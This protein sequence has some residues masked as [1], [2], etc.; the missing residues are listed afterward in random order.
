M[1]FRGGSREWD[2]CGREVE[3]F[4]FWALGFWERGLD[5]EPDLGSRFAAADFF[6]IDQ[7]DFAFAAQTTRR[8]LRE[9]TCATSIKSAARANSFCME[10]TD[11]NSSEWVS[12]LSSF[13]GRTQLVLAR[14]DGARPPIRTRPQ[15]S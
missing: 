4:R 5:C 13:E 11:L 7:S 1:V 10:V 8:K 2:R 14:F 6:F 15:M 3:G 9:S 12:Q